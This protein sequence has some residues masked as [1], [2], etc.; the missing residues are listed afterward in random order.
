MLYNLT[1]LR[2]LP[3][4]SSLLH[5]QLLSHALTVATQS[6]SHL[7]ALPIKIDFLSRPTNIVPNTADRH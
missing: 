4:I 2:S 3:P 6:T 1:I 5:R 7:I